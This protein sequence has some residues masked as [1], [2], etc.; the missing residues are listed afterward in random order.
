[1]TPTTKMQSGAAVRI[2]LSVL[3]L[4]LLASH[5]TAEPPPVPATPASA[6]GIVYARPFELEKGYPFA[7]RKERPTVK[8]GWI[9]VLEVT[10]ELVYPRQACEPVLYVGDTTAER[11]NLGHDSGKLIV[12]VP[13]DLDLKRA[14]VWFGTPG[15]PEQV[16]AKAVARERALADKAGVQPFGDAAI[17]SARKAGGDV[18]KARDIGSLRRAIAPLVEQFAADEHDLLE[19]LFLPPPATQPK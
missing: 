2:T 15:L 14:P 9:L 3:A 5:L 10:P 8:R 6:P 1:M 18:L 16:D 7:Y 11:I 13:G 4:T 19:S 17:K 12:V